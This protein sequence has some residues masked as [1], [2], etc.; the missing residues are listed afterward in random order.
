MF[1][2]SRIVLTTSFLINHYD[3]KAFSECYA[4]CP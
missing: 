3:A 1:L 4:L 2:K